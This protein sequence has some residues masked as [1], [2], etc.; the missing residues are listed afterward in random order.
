MRA[1][2]RLNRPGMAALLRS[3]GVAQEMERRAQ[4]VADL[5]R[6]L[7]PVVTGEYHDSI[8]VELA[9]TDRV[10]GRVVSRVPYALYLE[11]RRR[12]LGRAID[13]ARG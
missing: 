6:G 7:A 13:A 11:A 8:H 4:R 12:P 10:V 2:V 9:V 5:A 1:K 3:A